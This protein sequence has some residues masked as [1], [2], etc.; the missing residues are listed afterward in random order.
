VA[1]LRLDRKGQIHLAD[2]A[3]YRQQGDTDTHF[4]LSRTQLLVFL[5]G[6]F[7]LPFLFQSFFGFLLGRL[8][9]LLT[10]CHDSSPLLARNGEFVCL[11]QPHA[12]VD[13]A[14]QRHGEQ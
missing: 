11:P 3:G 8:L 1:S 5:L 14:G 10:F 12:W 4:A 13:C 6:P 2:G 9:G 7:R